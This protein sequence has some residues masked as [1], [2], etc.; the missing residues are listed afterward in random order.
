MRNIQHFSNENTLSNKKPTMRKYFRKLGLVIVPRTLLVL[1]RVVII[2]SLLIPNME[3]NVVLAATKSSADAPTTATRPAVDPTP[4]A[5]PRI[6]REEPRVGVRPGANGVFA[7]GVEPATSKSVPHAAGTIENVYHGPNKALF[8]ENQGQFEPEEKFRVENLEDKIQF[9]EDGIWYSVLDPQA[10]S[11]ENLPTSSS[12]APNKTSLTPDQQSDKPIS[13]VHINIQFIN[14]NPQP[15]IEGFDPID[16]NVSYLIGSDSKKWQKNVAVWGGIRYVDIYPGVDLEIKN[17]EDGQLDWQLVVKDNLDSF[18]GRNNNLK[19]TD[20]Q[21]MGYR[22]LGAKQFEVGTDR[23]TLSTNIGDLA[24]PAIKMVNPDG[25]DLFDNFGGQQGTNNDVLLVDPQG[26]PASLSPKPDVS[27]PD[28][29]DDSTPTETPQTSPTSTNTPVADQ[30]GETPQPTETPTTLPTSV[31]TDVSPSSTPQPTTELPIP[32]ALPIIPTSENVSPQLTPQSPVGQIQPVSY[33]LDHSDAANPTNR[34]PNI[35]DLSYSTFIGA[36]EGTAIAVD[37]DG[38]T[39]ITGMVGSSLY[40]HTNGAY[41]TVLHG[42]Y[43]IF[44]TELNDSGSGILYSTYLGGANEDHAN[45]IAVDQDGHAIIVGWTLSTD[46]PIIGTNCTGSDALVTKLHTDGG[47]LDYSR[48]LGGSGGEQGFGISLDGGGDAYVVGQTNSSDFPTANPFQ[49]HKGGGLY[50]G[51]VAELSSSGGLSYATYLGGSGEDCEIGTNQRECTIAVDGQ[52][53]AYIAGD[54]TSTNFPPSTTSRGGIDG[55]VAKISPGGGGLEYATRFGGSGDDCIRT[56]AISVDLAG[57]AYVG[58]TTSSSDFQPSPSFGSGS[59]GWDAFIVEFNANG[60]SVIYSGI[61]GGSGS[62]I[63][64]DTVVSED[65]QA[66]L[67][68]ETSSS[69]FPRT[70]DA[71]QDTFGGVRDGFVAKIARNGGVSYSTFLGG[72]SDDSALN[73]AMGNNGAIYVSGWTQSSNFPTTQNAYNRTN[74]GVFVSKLNLGSYTKPTDLITHPCCSNKNG[75]T[76]QRTNNSAGSTQ[77]QSGDPINTRNGS[78]DYSTG[79]LSIPTSA[80]EMVFQTLYSSISTTDYTALLGNGWS[81]NQEIYLSFDSGTVKFKTPSLNVFTFTDNGD[82]TYTSEPGITEILTKQI[83][84]PI[85]YRITSPDQSVYVFNDAGIIQSWSDAQGR[86]WTYTYNGNGLLHRVTDDSDQRYLDFTYT[87]QG[88]IDTVSDHTS[89]QVHFGYDTA[90]GDLT[91]MTDVL[92]GSWS[93]TYDTAH[94]LRIVTDPAGVKVVHTEYDAEGRA[95]RQY[96]SQSNP[97]NDPPILQIAYNDDGSRTITTTTTEDGVTHSYS[98]NMLSEQLGGSSDSMKGYDNNF[99]PFAVADGNH[100]ATSLSWSPDGK[101]LTQVMDP[102][103]G[104][105]DITYNSLNSVTE[106]IDPRGYPTDYTYDENNQ[107]PTLRTLVLSVEDPYS[108]TTG[109]TYTTSADTPAPIGLVKTITDPLGHTNTYTYDQ[110]GQRLTSEDNAGRV[111]H[112]TYDPLGRLQSITDPSGQANWTC[113]DAAGRVIRSVGNASGDGISPHPSPCDAVNYQTSSD[114]LKDRISSTL[115]DNSGNVIAT[116]DP[117]GITTRTYYDASN[118]PIIVIQNWVGQNVRTDPPPSYNS[119]YPEQNI[120][121]ETTYDL[122]GRPIATTDNTGTKTRTYFDSKGRAEFMVQN[123]YGQSVDINTPPTFDPA[124]P[125]RNVRTE[126][127]YDAGG[128][129]I[130]SIASSGIITRT[131]YDG[132]N[133]PIAVVQN[134]VGSDITSKVMP[135]YNSAYPDRNVRT[136][137]GYDQAGNAIVSTDANGIITRTYYDALNRP[138]TIIQNLVGWLSTNSTPPTCSQVTCTATQNL[139]TDYVYDA[140]GN[141]I[142]VVDPRNITTRTYFDE[143]NRPATVIQ[144]WVGNDLINDPVPTYDPAHPDQ[145]V[146]TDTIYDAEGKAI[147]SKQWNGTGYVITRTYFDDTNRPVSVVRN[148]TGS[149]V[150]SD[151]IPVY[152][153]QFPDRNIRSQTVFD[154]HGDAIATIDNSGMKTRT[155]YDILHR[156]TVVVRNLYGQTVE[157]TT[158]PTFDPAHPDRNVRSVTAYDGAGRAYRTTDAAGI[159]TQ[160]CYNGLSQVVKTVTNPS[161]TDPCSNYT[162]STNTAQDITTQ[163]VFDAAG[164]LSSQTDPNGKVISYQ[165]DGLNRVTSQLE[166]GLYTTSTSYDANGNKLTQTDAKGVITK[167]EYDALNRLTAVVENYRPGI[168]PSVEINV[169]TEYTYDASGNRLTIKDGRLNVTT[170][171][172]D[173]LNRTVSERDPL[174]HTTT[175]GYDGIGNRLQTVD[176]NGATISFQYDALNRPTLIDYP[177][178][179]SDVTYSY[180]A[181]GN[182]STMSDGLGTT[183]W[184]YDEL[185]RPTSIT[186]PLTGAVQYGYDAAGRRTSLTYPDQKQVGYI[187][188]DAGRLH[189]VTDW[190][191]LATTYT[192][193]RGSRPATITRPNNVVTNYQYDAAGRLGAISHSLGSQT[194]SSYTYGYDENG[195]RTGVTET[196]QLSAQ[197]PTDA[198]FLDRF[199]SGNLSAWNA[200]APDGGD[201]SVSSAA[202][203]QGTSGL[204]AIINDSNNIDVA[205]WTP[206]AETHY[207]ARFYFDPN[208]IHMADGDA[209]YL[210][211]GLQGST[212]TIF[213]IEINS[214][215]GDYQIR[216]EAANDSSGWSSTPW[217]ILTDQM[218]Y[219]EINWQAASSAGANNGV[220][221]LWLDGTQLASITNVDNDTRKVDLVKLGA[222]FGMDAGT[223]GTLYFDCFESRRS[224]YIGA[225]P[226]APLPPAP[227]TPPDSLF[228]DGFESGSFGAWSSSVT[229]SGDLAISSQAALIGTSGMQAV[230]D[231]NASIYA[232]DWSPFSETHYRA[233][234]YFDPNSLVMSNGNNFY[235]FTM[236]DRAATVLARVEL[237]SSTADYQVRAEAVNDSTG[238]STSP[239]VTITDGP[240][241]IELDWKAATVAGANNGALTYWVDGVQQY[242]VSTIDNDT[243]RVDLVYLG[244]VSGVDTGTRGTVYFDGFE[245]R[246]TSYIGPDPAGPPPPPFPTKT[247]ALFS[248]GFESAGLSAWSSDSALDS[249][250]LTVTST[251]AML[252]T[253]GLNVYINDNNNLYAADYSPFEETQYRARFYFDP[254]SIIMAHNDAFYLFYLLDRDGLVVARIEQRYSAGD[255]QVRAEAVN[256]ASA[257]TSTNWVTVTDGPHALELDWHAATAVGANNGVLTFWVDGSQQG[258]Y[259]NIDNDTRKVDQ[260]QLGGVGYIDTGTRGTVYFDGFVSHRTSYIGPD[261]SGPTPPPFP[262]KTDA[263]FSDGF[264]NG[265]LNAWWSGSAIDGGHLSVASTAALLGIKGLSVYINDNNNLYATDFSP[266]DENHYRARFYFDPN[267]IPMAHNDAFYIFYV[268]NRADVNLARVEFHFVA[269][270]YQL[271]ADAVNDANGWGATSPWVTITDGPHAV[272]LEWKAATAAGANNGAFTFW[273]DGTQQYTITNLDNDTRLADAVWLGAFDSIDTTTRGTVYFDG[274]ESRR[275]SYIGPDAGGPTPPPFPT[276]TDALFSDGFESGNL[277]AWWSGS[278]IDGGHLSVTNA[279]ALLGTKG[280]NVYINDNNNLY[281]TDFSPFDENHYRAR[282]YFD[283]NSVV[284]ANNDAF[285]IYYVRNRADVNLARVEFRSSVGDYQL[286][287]DAVN[288]ANG[289]GA[290]SPWVTITDGPHAIEIDWKAATAAGVNNGAFTLWVDGT[291]QYTITN[292]DNDT[293]LADAVWLGA[294]DSIDTTTRGTLYFDGFESRRTSYIGPDAGGPTPPPFPTKTDGLFSDGFESGGLTAWSASATDGGNLSASNASALIGTNGLQAVINDN[295]SIYLTDWQ[296]YI[297]SHY[298]ARFYFDPNSIT[299][300]DNDAHIIFLA[301]NRDGT[302]LVQIEFRYKAGD[303]VVRGNVINDSNGWSYSPW[304]AITDGP[305][306]IEFDWQAATAAGANNGVF[307]L[308]VNGVQ[309]YTLTTLDNDTRLVDYAQ[310]GAITGIDTG[311]RGTEYFDGF[312]SHRTT[313][314]GLDANA[315][316]TPAFPTKTDALFSDGF[317]DGTFNNWSASAIDGGHLSVTATAA[318]RDTKGM[319]AYINDNNLLY[320]TDWKPFEETDYRARFYFDPNTIT[321][322]NND[323]HYLFYALD[324]E[325]TVLVR[326]ELRYA[327]SS[328]QVHAEAVS[329]ASSWSSTT[330]VTISDAP[331]ALEFEWHTATAPGANNGVLNF[332]VDG[333]AQGSFTT[334]DNDTRRIDQV[335]LGGVYA[336][337]TGTRGTEYFDAFISRRTSYIGVTAFRSGP[338]KP[339]TVGEILGPQAPGSPDGSESA[340]VNPQKTDPVQVADPQ[341]ITYGQLMLANYRPDKRVVSPLSSTSAS[342]TQTTTIAYSYDPLGRLKTADY[343]DGT[344][345]H[346]TYDAV[347]NRLTEDLVGGMTFTYTYDTA[348]RLSGV[349]GLTYTWDNNGN[350]LSDGT[351]TYTYDHANRLKSVAQGSSTYTF[352]YR[353]N[354]NSSGVNGFGCEGDRVSQTVNGVTTHYVLDSA[355][356]LSQVLSDGTDTYLYGNEL[357]AQD[358]GSNP[359]YFLTDGLGSVRQ[360]VDALG[361][362]SLS[363]SFDPYGQLVNQIGTGSSD[364]GFTGEPTDSSINLVYLRS[365][366]YSSDTGRFIS[367]DTWQGDYTSPISNNAW[368]YAYA[369]PILNID[370]SGFSPTICP[371]GISCIGTARQVVEAAR[372]AYSKDGPIWLAGKMWSGRFDCGN[373]SWQKPEKGIDIIADFICE[374]GDDHVNFYGSDMLTKE[375]ARSVIVDSVRRE[376]YTSGDISVPKEKKFNAPEY[377]EALLDSLDANLSHYPDLPI[378]HVLGSFDYTA[379]H[380]GNGR[381][382]F[383]IDNRT[384]MSSG[385]HLPGRFPPESQKLNPLSL[386]QVIEENTNLENRSAI[387]LLVNY[388]DGSGNEIVSILRPL[389]RE[390]TG[391]QGSGIMRQTFTWSEKDLTCDKSLLLPWPLILPFLDIQ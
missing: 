95:D 348:N 358:P 242:A 303:Y 186:D 274:F 170:F 211:Y 148:W 217:T 120:R 53:S 369:N 255:Y 208:S 301:N 6:P 258:T 40:P 26:T 298:R 307:T 61:I 93:Y 74:I 382:S 315:L 372:W 109:Y 124:Y 283:P 24:I 143:L 155:Y 188:D 76:D 257:W 115:Y 52:G 16:T 139:F 69:N 102:L 309:K 193:D 355:A 287:A 360:L 12:D 214:V 306:A 136:E 272:E 261:L 32:T 107:D 318:L 308:W 174:N 183:H 164:N 379:M 51:F 50:D 222:V 361:N 302:N 275:T 270:D 154:S 122:L 184:S 245:S 230:I 38:N 111:T 43:E 191:A 23:I 48:C 209:F 71:Y 349:G 243:R 13:G 54:T 333:N 203:I 345:F 39:Y 91:S 68:G 334:I 268:R 375:L 200:N 322:A 78:F 299:M 104:K 190:D 182:Q 297:E 376:F 185:N 121:T 33:Y 72:S 339:I 377:I 331:H 221:G 241:A 254:N 85:T 320:L 58:G 130:A 108:H 206:A 96:D 219:I 30:V 247:D 329:D 125:D 144:N 79:A 140:A 103:S 323:A 105:T 92:G 223:H 210:F 97:P 80:G 250:H 220:L 367:Q 158:P 162:P 373:S 383:Q 133:R 353:C 181:A 194:L 265:N 390:Q 173:N 368:L 145:N 5:R 84:P 259:S 347:G 350:L 98:R 293:R 41:Q 106:V 359:E 264:E 294:F 49:E 381:I 35:L 44:V 289:W 277:N 218:H 167:Y 374:R 146:R 246:R 346:Y 227:P 128:N 312:V 195:N 319:Q 147:A 197:E 316:P 321:M 179:D 88:K 213:R 328:Y 244:A 18:I 269:G 199:E 226:S 20:Q 57:N 266:F 344:F 253:K 127:V 196:R 388:R 135:T 37:K 25:S 239:W 212:T 156:A 295:N 19:N 305:Q 313:S 42:G 263:L 207:R 238:W 118:R 113:Y 55:F 229:D 365:R 65:G 352:S 138:M 56:C 132:N 7:P 228:A 324:R 159:V 94:H 180:D 291:Q 224:S 386:Q 317:E 389:R 165:Y 187:Y 59:G 149:D 160:S 311:T 278:A 341:P 281:A 153:P 276:K 280:L 123:L 17:G 47:G 161:V 252:G 357:L 235:L 66:Y 231:D 101:N 27:I 150:F 351:S 110:F 10:I 189:T 330:W 169:R 198:I 9:G 337:D 371:S 282:F 335:Q 157:N 279:A 29:Q 8:I 205:D 176:A 366:Y 332:W 152:D 3:P 22:I 362:I 77:G 343:G 166:A 81:H 385:T 70:A 34:L 256:D 175:S 233:R 292:L 234:F 28:N 141:Q 378:T 82:G 15:K 90:T 137:T 119:A 240:H 126:T 370:P 99:R 171:T 338:R 216:A 314:I 64:Y 83:G 1:G 75:S 116:I 89:R 284:M 262:T 46:Y 45:G 260:V 151:T 327:S 273:L 356:F 387:D 2:C 296:P 310:L 285:F 177:A 134:W 336:I 225:D 237:R 86:S 267:S 172:Y 290:T 271:R 363:Q 326:V 112:Y 354:G 131:Y 325:G 67:I 21:E 142:A 342:G 236:T 300:A 380:S 62:D 192:Y 215:Q 201:L 31:S 304:V 202:A 178:P 168:T 100:N 204:Q 163:S 129:V 60:E 251:A 248:D 117:N 391:G 288:D 63:G 232:V 36:G 286:R 11:N 73:V 384:D 4:N 87:A 340:D 364:F 114:P 249:G 14:S